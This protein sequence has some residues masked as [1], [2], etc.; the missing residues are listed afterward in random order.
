MEKWINREK[1][2]QV[3]GKSEECFPNFSIFSS[4]S[5]LFLSIYPFAYLSFSPKRE[6]RQ[7]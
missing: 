5:F 6:Q 7:T 2:I 4:I 3:S 1:G